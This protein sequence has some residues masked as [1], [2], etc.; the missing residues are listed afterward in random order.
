ML[1]W[2]SQRDRRRH[3][4]KRA[5]EATV[6]RGRAPRL[7]PGPEIGERR[8]AEAEAASSSCA[9]A[10]SM[11]PLRSAPTGELGSAW[12]DFGRMNITWDRTQTFLGRKIERAFPREQ[13]GPNRQNERPPGLPKRPRYVMLDAS[14]LTGASGV[15]GACLGI[16]RARCALLLHHDRDEGGRCWIIRGWHSFRSGR[17]V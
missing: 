3:G 15:R 13:F 16:R 10:S 5:A 2:H 4:A 12:S 17:R 1:P 6:G 14:N 7:T 9:A 11:R 8:A